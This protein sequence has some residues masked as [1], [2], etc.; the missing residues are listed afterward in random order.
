MIYTVNIT[1]PAINEEVVLNAES[2]DEAK[3]LAVASALQ[4]QWAAA[5]IIVTPQTAGS[6]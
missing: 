3:D 5:E 2:E 4:R 6:Q 1:A